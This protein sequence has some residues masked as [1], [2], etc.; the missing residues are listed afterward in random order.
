MGRGGG[1]RVHLIKNSSAL[2]SLALSSTQTSNLLITHKEN[3]KNK[4]DKIFSWHNVIR[5][6]LRAKGSG[7]YNG[8]K[9]TT[10]AV[11]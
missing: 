8:A 9:L 10:S 5:Y 6:F 7:E 1:K 3:D 4:L 11:D 2:L